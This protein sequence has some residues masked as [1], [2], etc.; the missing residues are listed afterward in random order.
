MSKPRNFLS[1]VFWALTYVFNFFNFL[2]SLFP[3]LLTSFLSINHCL[4]K[5]SSFFILHSSF[6]FIPLHTYLGFYF[7]TN[8]ILSN[9]TD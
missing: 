5:N 8:K 2:N 9:E 1:G 4:K 6:F 3:Y 7:N